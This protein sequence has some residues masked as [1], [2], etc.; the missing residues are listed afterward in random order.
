VQ[1][2]SSHIAATRGRRRAR[3]RPTRSAYA[4]ARTPHRSRSGVLWRAAGV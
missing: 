1:E 4:G 3:R 2:P